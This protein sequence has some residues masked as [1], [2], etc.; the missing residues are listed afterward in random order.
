MAV[1]GTFGS[2]TAARLGIY[3]SQASLNVT[4]NNIAN[5]NT[6]GYT[7]Q[8]MDL[9]SLYS[10][11][12]DRY[13]NMFNM[14][15]G[16]GV[17][18]SGVS[19]LRDPYLDIRFRN[20]QASL[21]EQAAKLNGLSDL[22]AILDEVG[23][24]DYD[25]GIIENQLNDFKSQ[26]QTLTGKI[27]SEEYDTLVRSS[28]ATLVKLFNTAAKDLD[29][30]YDNTVDK[31]K[32][33]IKDVNTI[34]SNIRDL[35]VQI[36]DAA[37]YGDKALELRDTRNV[38]IDELSSYMKIDVTYTTEKIDQY[39]EVE[40][41][42]I[43][44]A[45]TS[46]A[47]NLVDGIYATQLMMPEELPKPNPDYDPTD[48]RGM[49]YLDWSGKPTDNPREAAPMLNPDDGKYVSA[50][51]PTKF[52]NNP[53]AAAKVPNNQKDFL[54]LDKNG[55]PVKDIKD[56]AVTLNKGDDKD[57]FP[58]LD[59][60]GTPVEKL[61]DA[62][63]KNNDPTMQWLDSKGRPTNDDKKAALVENE[64]RQQ[65]LEWV[66]DPTILPDG[67][68]YVPTNDINKAALQK[69]DVTP[70]D[71]N[72]KE[73][74]KYLDKDDNPTDKEEDAAKV[75]NAMDGEKDLNMY[76]I[77]LDAL[78]DAK[79]R[80]RRD[81][82]NRVINEI[83]DIDDVT[84][85]GSLQAL[86]ELL[87]EEGE[88]VS[89]EDL[90][91]DPEAATKRG[92]PYYEKTLDFLAKTFA[93][94][95]NEANQIEPGVLYQSQKGADGINYFVDKDG[96]FITNDKGMRIPSNATKT[97]PDNPADT[98]EY[99]VD[100]NGEFILENGNKIPRNDEA[101][102]DREFLL[103]NGATIKE[104]YAYYDGGVLFSNNGAG[105]D[106]ANIDARNIS[107]S[108][109]WGETTVRVLNTKEPNINGNTTKGSNI[110]HMINLMNEKV[111]YYTDEV[112][113]DASHGKYFVGT[114]QEMYRNISTTLADD[115]RT[116]TILYN[117]FDGEVLS[118]ENNRQSVSGVDLNE[119]ATNMMQFQKSYSAACRLLT[120]IDSM[121]D[122]LI[123][124]TAI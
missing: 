97:D 57:K 54:Y 6:K 121:L 11:G 32:T 77:Q 82:H 12:A 120:T 15:V 26:L 30:Q 71:P 83:V 53:E 81:E 36:R 119:E 9:V 72:L 80:C 25:F 18:C 35:N 10:G 41:I 43:N 59:P 29:V 55:R 109:G 108:K 79:G 115:R 45:D 92:I 63:V 14:N 28:A 74:M 39:S 17:L 48:P 116:T 76:R 118:L 65:Y 85:Q 70:Y 20:E 19:Q 100:S 69:N 68:K 86:R 103:A 73:G 95:F 34:L 33:D 111:T 89:E 47:V 99:Y 105:N 51:D 13:A 78:K 88:F 56:A 23:K 102:A 1:I 62:V 7:R 61:E 93:E 44:L 67:G 52:T 117:S 8:R 98:T 4:G 94:A 66:E 42:V 84:L 21:G 46:P 58:Y 114:F 5:I 110:K 2:F 87:T 40:K 37:L 123:N 31:L 16:Y 107:I 112:Q 22:S 75:P 101:V 104:E 90:K 122:K 3:A 60:A 24:G 50:A 27:G 113:A 38:L 106:T 49:E 96:N 124:G 64:N 91:F